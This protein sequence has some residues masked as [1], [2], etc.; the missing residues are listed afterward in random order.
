MFMLTLYF[1]LF[2]V[3]SFSLVLATRPLTTLIHELGHAIPAILLTR[4]RVTMY[5]G[6]YGKSKGSIYIRIGLLDIYFKYN[7]FAWGSGLC[8]IPSA[9]LSINRQIVYIMTGPLASSV[10]SF[11]ACFAAFSYDLHG[12]LKLFLIIFFGSAIFDL[13]FNL[14]PRE[15]AITS[16]NEHI[17]YCDGYQIKL[18][19]NYKRFA[20]EH[21][22]AVELYQN[23]QYAEASSLFLKLLNSGL[24]DQSTYY[25]TMASFFC[26]NNHEQVIEI[27]ERYT[28]HHKLSIE[29]LSTLGTCHAALGQFE[30]GIEFFDSVLKQDSNHGRSMLNKAYT[31]VQMLK[32]KEA[33]E[34]FDRC[35]EG[36]DNLSYIYA[37]RG[38]C[39]IRIGEHEEGLKE[40][41]HSVEI[42]SKNSYGYKNLG[43]YHFEK[44]E[45]RD[46][47]MY[48]K[49]SKE[50]N[51]GTH[52]IDRLLNEVNESINS[53]P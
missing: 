44:E 23:G 52:D 10:I 20:K 37:N 13:A 53:N 8:L 2:L 29:D 3:G 49:K 5:V 36:S 26:D 16:E 22:E 40:I 18:L 50:I 51:K 24:R 48:F 42:D 43:I 45:F 1:A 32:F 7:P 27:Y 38:L 25:A 4:Q 41:K 15:T 21:D 11:I 28:K 14:Q 33:I 31:L 19:F 34:L 9:G 6:S 30:K 12:F 47:L 39:K 17:G 46:A 35:S